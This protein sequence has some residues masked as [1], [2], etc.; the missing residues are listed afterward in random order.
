MSNCDNVYPFV[1][2]RSRIILLSHYTDRTD[3]A[4]WFTST[5]TTVNASSCNLNFLQIYTHSFV[6]PLRT[7]T[8]FSPWCMRSLT[9]TASSFLT[10]AVTWEEIEIKMEEEITATIFNILI[11]GMI[12]KRIILMET[13]WDLARNSV[14]WSSSSPSALLSSVRAW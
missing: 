7:L 9:A 13:W 5:K 2:G 6:K 14:S 10:I 8:W 1:L 12:L 4:T 3:K 11:A